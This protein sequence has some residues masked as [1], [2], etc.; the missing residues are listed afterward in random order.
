MV[1]NL[2]KK[3]KKCQ[4]PGGGM[5]TLGID[6]YIIVIDCSFPSFSSSSFSSPSLSC[7]SSS[8]LVILL[9]PGFALLLVIFHLA[10]AVVFVV[11]VL[12]LLLI[13]LVL[14][15]LSCCC[16]CSSSSSSSLDLYKLISTIETIADTKDTPIT[17]P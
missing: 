2:T 3:N 1:G 6:S 13:V 12:L 5:G 16:C 9:E 15:V 4:M 11:V 10:V 14:L 7:F 8:F 17:F